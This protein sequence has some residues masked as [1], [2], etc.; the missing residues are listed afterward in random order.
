M[1]SREYIKRLN[2]NIIF[3]LI[4]FTI[5]SDLFIEAYPRKLFYIGCYLSIFGLLFLA[6]FFWKTGRVF[7]NGY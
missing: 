1:L 2:V 6:F 5:G 7:V 3:I 4:V